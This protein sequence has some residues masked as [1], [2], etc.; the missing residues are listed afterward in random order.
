MDYVAKQDFSSPRVGELKKG[1]DVPGL[2]AHVEK[3]LVEVGFIEKKVLQQPAEKETKPKK[4]AAKATKAK[5]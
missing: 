1:D 4:T 5:S 2:P 3:Q